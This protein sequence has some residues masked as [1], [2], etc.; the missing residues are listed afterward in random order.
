MSNTT[1]ENI[2]LGCLSFGPRSGYEIKKII[3]MSSSWFYN[4]SYGSIY[5]ILKKHEDNGLVSSEETVDN[6]RYK[7]IYQLTPKG[8][9][10]FEKWM[11]ESPKLMT[12]KYEMAVKLMFFAHLKPGQRIKQVEQHI[13]QLI[14][15]KQELEEIEPYAASE[16]DFYQRL[17]L[18]WGENLYSFLIEWFGKFLDELKNN[19][20]DV[21]INSKTRE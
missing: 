21:P 6:G 5:P 14:L 9:K 16:G 13:E 11:L 2:I 4:A 10:V 18:D 20:G 12:V 7:R 15:F 1:V 19:S 8:Y 17:I 3:S